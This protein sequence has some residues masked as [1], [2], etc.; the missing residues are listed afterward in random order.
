M[1]ADV[2]GGWT[3]RCCAVA[4]VVLIVLAVILVLGLLVTLGVLSFVLPVSS[5]ISY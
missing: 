4:D 5:T 1:V 2:G 3:L